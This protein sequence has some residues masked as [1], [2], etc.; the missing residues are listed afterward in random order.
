MVLDQEYPLKSFE[1]KGSRPTRGAKGLRQ[2]TKLQSKHLFFIGYT[3]KEEMDI[4][5]R[6]KRIL[7]MLNDN[8]PNAQQSM[9]TYDTHPFKWDNL[10]NGSESCEIEI[11]HCECVVKVFS[12]CFLCVENNTLFA[13]TAHKL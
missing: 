13:Q 3:K 7:S 4:I 11:T 1:H 12:T 9:E 10:P 2:F 8:N 5:I 6:N